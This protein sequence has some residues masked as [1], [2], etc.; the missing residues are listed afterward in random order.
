M[1]QLL[2]HRGPGDGGGGAGSLVH[3]NDVGGV[4]VVEL[5]NAL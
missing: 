4:V 1:G 3:P 2:L 5:G